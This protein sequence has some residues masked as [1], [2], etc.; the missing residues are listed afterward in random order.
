MI[1]TNNNVCWGSNGTETKICTKFI[2]GS[3]KKNNKNYKAEKN[4]RKLVHEH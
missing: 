3:Q 2:I 1:I 4:E